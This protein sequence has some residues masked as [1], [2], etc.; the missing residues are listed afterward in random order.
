M[1]SSLFY[2]VQ[3]FL[4]LIVSVQA[5]PTPELESRQA[6]TTLSTAQIAAFKPFTLYASTGY[7]KPAQTANW[8]CGANCNA[9]PTFQPVASGGDGDVTQF[10]YV[11]F[12]PTLKTVIVSHQ[13]TDTSKLLPLLTD[14][15]II[16]EPLDSSLFPGIGSSV[17]VHSGFRGAQSRAAR[18]VLAAVQT[19]LSRFN[20]TQVT[21]TGH[22]L[23]GAIAL[24]DAVYL[25]LH[26][27]ATVTFK[28]FTY[29]MPRVGNQAFADYVDAHVT[30]LSHVNNK[31]DV[32]PI[33]PGRFLGFHHPSG[34]VHITESNAW[35]ACPGQDNTN[36]QCIIG[37]VPNIF[38]GDESDH[39][40]PYDGVLMGC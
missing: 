37:T 12:D 6:I 28:T 16:Q 39:D 30:S 14:I 4:A 25:P 23:G 17:K 26:L 22:S 31:K 36:S 5:L 3:T 32:V 34:E 13:G 7:C 10:W 9:N 35:D 2:L 24:L 15:D 38:E 21:I 11:G 19:A 29:G 1:T 33:L 8:T 20:A 27:P 18:P 40:G